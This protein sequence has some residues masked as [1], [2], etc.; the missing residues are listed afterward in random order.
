[1]TVREYLDLLEGPIDAV[2]QLCN[3]SNL[4]L[5]RKNMCKSCPMYK[6]GGK[7]CVLAQLTDVKRSLMYAVKHHVN[8]IDEDTD[9]QDPHVVMFLRRA[10]VLGCSVY[11]LRMCDDDYIKERN[12][13]E[14]TLTE[15]K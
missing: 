9:V 2:Y 12:L 10:V 7:P 6:S 11:T 13:I 3:A 5:N 4:A 14:V 15:D 1:M 8:C